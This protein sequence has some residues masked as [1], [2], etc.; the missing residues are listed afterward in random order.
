[1]S[2]SVFFNKSF[3]H[4]LHD[5]ENDTYILFYIIK[6]SNTIIGPDTGAG[7]GSHVVT[8]QRPHFAL[9]IVVEM[10]ATSLTT[11]AQSSNSLCGLYAC[12]SIRAPV[13]L[14]PNITEKLYLFIKQIHI[15]IK[16][17]LVVLSFLKSSSNKTI[18]L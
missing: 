16:D 13:V 8:P 12:P 15:Y 17:H 11:G 6:H 7:L 5:F 9:L 18:F 2:P 1:M 14:R 3:I 10:T 4:I